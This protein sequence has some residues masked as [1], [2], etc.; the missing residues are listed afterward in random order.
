MRL[1]N[2]SR[3]RTLMAAHTHVKD[4]QAPCARAHT[5]IK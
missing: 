5:N 4:A 1:N 3:T 2:C